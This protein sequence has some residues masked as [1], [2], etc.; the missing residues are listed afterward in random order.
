LR[1]EAA[2]KL[3]S[4]VL[5]AS[6]LFGVR[7]LCA[8]SKVHFIVANVGKVKPQSAEAFA[9]KMFELVTDE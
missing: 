4:H 6:S 8:A 5:P 9:A 1:Q 7:L 3:S 2:E